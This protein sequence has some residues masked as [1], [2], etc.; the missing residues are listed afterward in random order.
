[1]GETRPVSCAPIGARP[2]RTDGPGLL[3]RR[4]TLQAGE[5]LPSWLVRLADANGYDQQPGLLTSLLLGRQGTPDRLYDHPGNAA[6][7]ETYRRLAALTGASVSTLWAATVHRFAPTLTPP[8]RTVAGLVSPDGVVLPLLAAGSRREHLRPESWGVFC[9][10]CLAET[11]SH[12]LIWMALATAAC[13]RHGC[14]LMERCE[15]CGTVP[16]M[17]DIVAATCRICGTDFRTCSATSL[18]ADTFGLFA[19][20]VIQGWLLGVRVPPDS[21][22]PLPDLPANVAYRVVDGLRLLVQGVGPHWRYLHPSPEGM[23]GAPAEGY[24]LTPAQSLT[25]YATALK[26]L[27]HWPHGFEAFLDACRDRGTGGDQASASDGAPELDA[28]Y[29]DWVERRWGNAAFGFVRDAIEGYVLDRYARHM[30]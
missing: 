5:S 25:L 19:Q 13:L 9:P 18:A 4:P 17:R 12:R 15:G 2:G 1:M 21:S 14:L 8:G 20:R 7:T 26:A 24:L 27:L 6:H 28:F 3:L 29:R 16:S 11:A 10:G 30:T 22:F 23:G